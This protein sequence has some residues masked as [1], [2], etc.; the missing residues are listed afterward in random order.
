MLVPSRDF[1]ALRLNEDDF[2]H[3]SNFA[4]IEITCTFCD[5]TDDDEVDCQECLVDV[6][7]G[8][9]EVRLNARVEFNETTCPSGKGA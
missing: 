5:T 1:D 2:R 7:D 3:G 6:G 4:P 9:F 8:K